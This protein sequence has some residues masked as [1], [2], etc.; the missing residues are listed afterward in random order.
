MS[1][2]VSKGRIVIPYFSLIKSGKCWYC[3]KKEMISY[4]TR[5]INKNE[6]SNFPNIRPITINVG[7]FILSYFFIYKNIHY[8]SYYKARNN[9]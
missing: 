3:F 5:Y 2:L 9:S 8:K 7:Y 4:K 1:L 6:L